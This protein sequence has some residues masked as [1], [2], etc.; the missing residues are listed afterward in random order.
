M[1]PLYRYLKIKDKSPNILTRM[2]RK[3]SR[4]SRNAAALGLVFF[5]LYSATLCPT[6]F[7]GDS[8]EI[9][10]AIWSRGVI[11]PPGYPLFTL[12]GKLFLTLVPFGEP[13]FRI[14]VFVALAGAGSVALLYRVSRELGTPVLASLGAAAF[15][16]VS[17]TFWS[18][19]NRVEVYSFHVLLVLLATWQCLCYRA[20]GEEKALYLACI[21]LGLGLAHHLTIVLLVPGLLVL[22]GVR[23]W[24]VAGLARRLLIGIALLAVSG[25]PLYG[26]LWVRLADPDVFWAH[27]TGSSYRFYF[28]MPRSLG[29]LQRPLKLLTAIFSENGFGPL[30]VLAAL[31]GLALGRR[32]PSVLCGLF[33]MALA[34]TLYC[35]CYTIEDI[36]PYYLVV[37]ALGVGLVGLVLG[38]VEN[39]LVSRERSLAV[40]L[41]ACFVLPLLGLALNFPA[42]NLHTAT[43]IRQLA[44]Q[45]LSACAP[46]SVLLCQGDEDTYSL[47]YTHN[48]LK[49]RP[50]VTVLDTEQL[51]LLD[52]TQLA[53]RPL[54]STYFGT[55]AQNLAQLGESPGLEWLRANYLPVPH[56]VILSLI[57]K[58]TTPALSKVLAEGKAAW[59]IIE[60]PEL[61]LA[62]TATEVDGDYTRRHYV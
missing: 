14:G 19:C 43:G 61:P 35:F 48:V 51:S 29:T 20:T 62:P 16:G 44:Q 56:G 37:L 57:P 21:A 22:C 28:A 45:K 18:Q 46:G 54:A 8:G 6:V 3:L 23:L 7:R 55:S 32:N 47:R 39:A 9:I 36:A 59:D 50:D 33:F 38:Q 49:L 30:S 24:R 53:K 27:V 40:R 5:M 34:V 26:L 17:L 25:L 13:A 10:T 15:F 41:A 2:I 31:G 4:D 60:L 1:R 11:H 42:C 12:I 52:M 58:T